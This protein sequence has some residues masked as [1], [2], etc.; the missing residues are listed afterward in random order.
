MRKRLS[1]LATALTL[2]LANPAA[3]GCCGY[4]VWPA[5]APGPWALFAP[6]PEMLVV[7]QG[8]VPAPF[9]YQAPDL[10]PFGYPYVGFVFSG[11]PYG[12]YSPWVGAPGWG[13]P[14]G[15]Y[16]ARYR[17]GARY[18]RPAPGVVRIYR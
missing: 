5:F 4:S 16:R 1:L 2:G 15:Y 14:P 6:P 13:P 3:A 10:P 7:N 12:F 9:L 11:Y 17:A 8:P 18:D